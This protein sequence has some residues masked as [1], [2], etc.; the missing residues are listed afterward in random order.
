MSNEMKTCPFCGSDNVEISSNGKNEY[1][2]TC[3][4]CMCFSPEA[5]TADDA[6]ERWN[7]RASKSV[8][9]LTVGISATSFSATIKEVVSVLEKYDIN[10]KDLARIEKALIK[11]VVAK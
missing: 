11:S 6:I 9:S 1:Y 4:I 5:T 2:G 10:T 8:G 7:N 3:N